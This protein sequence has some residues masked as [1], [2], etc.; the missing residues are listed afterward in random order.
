MSTSVYVSI[1]TFSVSISSLHRFFSDLHLNMGVPCCSHQNVD[2]KAFGQFPHVLYLLV[3]VDV[4]GAAVQQ[5]QQQTPR[6]PADPVDV[7]VVAALGGSCDVPRDTGARRC[8]HAC[9]CVERR[10]VDSHDR[11]VA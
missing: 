6:R 1:H 4:N 7:Q 2:V 5:L 8:Q 11:C 3:T 10:A 9:M